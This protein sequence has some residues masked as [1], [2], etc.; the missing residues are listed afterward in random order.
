MTFLQER[1][2]NRGILLGNSGHFQ[3]F[4]FKLSLEFEYDGAPKAACMA[5]SLR[6]EEL[7]IGAVEFRN[8]C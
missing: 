2:S 7:P 3:R 5:V 4:G 6:D 8:S 1:S